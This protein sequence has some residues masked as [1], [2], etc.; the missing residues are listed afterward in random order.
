VLN[1]KNSGVK[2]GKEHY[3]FSIKKFYVSLTLK[4]E[5][6]YLIV[7]LIRTTSLFLLFTT[8]ALAQDRITITKLSSPIVL[9]GILDEVAWAEIDALP[10][11]QYEPTFQGEMHEQTR[12]RVAYDE[13]FIY[14]SGEM[15]TKDAKTIAV[16]SLYRDRYS[17]DDVFAIIIDGFNDDQNATW[18]F[19]NPAGVRFDVA[20]SND[21]DFSGGRNSFNSSYNTF[22][23]VATKQTDEGW[24]AEMRIPFS[25]IGIIVEGET[26][27]IGFITYRWISN[28]NERHIFPAIPPNWNLGN[29]KPSQAYDVKLEGVKAKNPIYFTPYGLGGYSSLSGLNT[30]STA[31]IYDNDPKVELG[32]DVKYNVTNNLTLDVTVN[33]DFAQVEADDQQLNLSRFSLFF[34]EKRQFFQQRSSQFDF[35]FGGDRAFYS[36]RIGLDGSGNPVRILGGARLTGRVNK[37]DIGFLNLQTGENGNLP[38]ENFGVLRLKNEVFNQRSFVGGILTSRLSGDGGSNIVYGLDADVNI[39]GENFVEVRASQSQD[40]SAPQ[41]LKETEAYRFAVRNSSS[42]GFNY[43]MVFNRIGENY[44]PGIGFVRIPGTTDNQFAIGYGTLASEESVFQRTNIEIS[45]FSRNYNDEYKFPDYDSGLQ[46]K[47]AGLGWSGRFKQYGNLSLNLNIG[48]EVIR[49]SDQ[50]NLPGRI[51]IPAGTYSTKQI[52]INYGLSESWKV[53]GNIQA[54]VGQLYDGDFYSFT[55]NPRLFASKNLEIGGSYNITHL[56]FPDRPQRTNT[57]FTTH[58]GQFRGQ[59]AFNKKASLNMFLQYSNVSEL[60][61]ANVRFRYNYSEGRDFWVVLNEQ[62]YADRNPLEP[63]LP[64]LP[65]LQSRSILL[66]YTHTFIY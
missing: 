47:T 49:N 17:N 41:N 30:D 9:D 62:S 36:R 28:I 58:L 63:N 29:A 11:V 20:L 23:D 2:R 1:W 43:Q 26:A 54:N 10:M 42:A 60:V 59:Y 46:V 51:F 34:P 13:N 35:N 33:T 4:I 18:F 22:W 32:F 14:I 44:N 61:G 50:F 15:Y 25:S 12:I 52:S 57:V 40:D 8:V 45:L 16:N 39:A 64:R 3:Q 38:S 6:F 66:K 37:L 27:E 48:K 19:T 7:R 53:A 24:F 31:Y 55:I 65:Y 21:A 5:G 56:N